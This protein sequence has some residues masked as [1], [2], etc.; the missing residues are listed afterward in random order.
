MRITTI[1]FV[2]LC[3]GISAQGV[4][5]Q[6]LTAKEVVE[7]ADDKFRGQSSKAE[8]EMSIIRPSW[9]RTISMKMWSL[10]TDFSMVYITAPARDEGTAYLNREKEIWN[11]VPRISRVVKLPPSMMSQSWMGSDFTNDDLVEQSSIVTDYTH[12]FDGDS[13]I[14]G[15]DCY[16]IVMQPKPKAAVVWDKVVIWISKEEYLQLRSEFYDEFGDLINVM[17]G[18]EVETLDGRTLPTKLAMIPQDKEGHRTVL[19]YHQINF[20]V[21]LNK[22]FFTIQNMKR[23]Q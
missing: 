9:Q 19:K 11:W 16:K 13:T 4:T 20:G 10:G 2:L 21:D 12:S 14:S 23:V 18:S 5:A 8:V 15:Y 6:A 17:E 22:N 1:V 3:V 7:R